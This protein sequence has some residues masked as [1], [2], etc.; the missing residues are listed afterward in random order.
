MKTRYPFA[1]VGVL[2]WLMLVL[3][4]YYWIH[5]PVT[6]DFIRAS[7]G[8]VLDFGSVF[9]LMALGGDLGKVLVSRFFQDTWMLLSRA[10]R[11]A[12]EALIGLGMLSPLIFAVG[13]VNL[14][15]FSMLFLLILLAACLRKNLFRWARDLWQWGNAFR[16]VGTWERGLAVFI[17]LNLGMA[18][19]MA[20]LPPTKFDALTYHLVGP[21]LWVQ[22][23][24]FSALPHSH[25]FGFPQYVNTLYAGQMA[26]LLGRFNGTAMIHGFF[27]VFTLMALGGYGARRFNRLVG[28]MAVAVLLSATSIWMQFSWAYVDLVGIGT[29]ALALATLELWKETQKTKFLVLAGIFAGLALASKY[30]A[31]MVGFAGGLYILL[32]SWRQGFVP[33]IRYGVLFGLAALVVVSPWLIRNVFFYE[34]P[35]YPLGPTTGEWDD[36][37]NQWYFYAREDLSVLREDLWMILLLPLTPTFLGVEGGAPFSATIGPLFVLLIPL[38][39]LT[40][41][42]IDEKWRESLKGQFWFLLFLHGFW[43]YSMTNRWTETRLVLSIFA[44]MSLLAAAAFES[45]RSLPEKPLN[46]TWMLRTIVVLI[47]VITAVNHIAGKRLE[48]GEDFQGTTLVSHFVDMK[49][50]DYLTG[51]ISEKEYLEDALGWYLPAMEKV[52]DLPDDSYILFLWETRSLY[53]EE[54]TLT[55]E[56]DTIIIRWWHDRRAVGDGSAEAIL[57]HWRGRGVTHVLVW[58]TGQEFEFDSPTRLFTEEDIA[59]WEKMETLLVPVWHGEDVYTLYELS[60]IP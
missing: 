16:F 39:L 5:K 1:L 42:R 34:N 57:T 60:E 11:L 56:E 9:L 13:L 48:D 26:L 4:L 33:V 45:L 37:S 30:N 52:N 28:L 59:E 53:C 18:F 10:E 8:A 19:L 41:G 17:L 27:G 25:F 15:L 2:L 6:P 12:G 44:P 35:I 23:G 51:I 38:L 50:L 49:T 54:K 3:F 46:I 24:R 47:L 29:G 32:Y 36:L 20:A 58:E 7:G 21:K 22:E 43:L 14:S 55:C 40:W 31:A